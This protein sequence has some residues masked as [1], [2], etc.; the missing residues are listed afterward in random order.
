M[1][2]KHL[3]MRTYSMKGGSLLASRETWRALATQ[4]DSAGQ[5]GRAG[6]HQQPLGPEP[7]PGPW[8]ESQGEAEA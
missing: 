5:S 1:Q 3:F 4:A 2:V 7:G 6:G 8:K